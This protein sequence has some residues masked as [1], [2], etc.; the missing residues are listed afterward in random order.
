M[1]ETG[2]LDERD[3]EILSGLLRIRHALEDELATLIGRPPTSGGIGEVV[4]AAVF[5]IDLAP[6]G[7]TPGYDGHFASGPLAGQSVN[8]KAYAERGYMLDMGPHDCD[9]YL[10]LMGPPRESSHRGR[11]LPFR[12]ASVHLFR[13]GQ[14]LDT[15]KAAG[16]GVGIATSVRK[17]LWE[18]AEV[19]PAS[20][21]QALNLTGDQRR[22]LALF[23]R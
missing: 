16:V 17:A 15:L 11:S 3:L 14:L 6:T 7:V 19:H 21:S 9:W 18:A 2:R 1:T 5:D 13:T 23:E 4:A 12:I 8:V 10:V 20:R 22:L